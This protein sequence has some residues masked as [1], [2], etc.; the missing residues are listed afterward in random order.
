MFCL[1]ASLA[2]LPEGVEQANARAL[3]GSL[4]QIQVYFS[5]TVEKGHGRVEIRRHWMIDDPE[6]IARLKKYTDVYFI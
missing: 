5:E 3:A 1:K 2:F 6:I 4:P